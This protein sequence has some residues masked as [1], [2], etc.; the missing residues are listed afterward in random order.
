MA[1]GRGERLW[2]L[3][4]DERPKQFL[5]LVGERT[6][7]QGTAAR[8]TPLV[9]WEKTFVVVG[10]EHAHLVA[11]QLP[12]LPE[13][14]ILAEPMGRGTAPCVG[15]AALCVSP[16][17]PAGVMVVLPADHVIK[18]EKRF[19]ALLEDAVAIASDGKHLVTLG[20]P[21]TFPATGY[22]YIR[23]SRP[24]ARASCGQ[25]AL[26]VE[27]FTE[28]PDR[29]TA[30]RFLNEGGYY[31]NSGMFIWRADA[32]LREIEEHIPALY[33]GLTEIAQHLGRPDEEAVIEEVYAR[34]ESLSID[35]G[36]MEKSRRTCVLPTGAIGW[37]DV[38][39]WAA[40]ESVLPKDEKGNVLLADHRGI[41]TR[42]TTVVGDG[43]RTI[44]TIGVRDLVIVDTS[45]ALLVMDKS[46]AQDVKKILPLLKEAGKEHSG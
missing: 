42:G 41:D 46:R 44:V 29:A 40:L 27:R 20:I 26:A 16:I 25:Q 13:H 15:L 22:G 6:M 31:W 3:S 17:D 39:D 37:S 2:P 35:H 21:P 8:V 33:R 1:G 11:E 14:N 43:T 24:C 38:G 9:P 45:E 19:L 34:Q 12:D 7:L 23:A 4:T 5:K 30:E 18:D 28:K 32:I 36:I 10:K